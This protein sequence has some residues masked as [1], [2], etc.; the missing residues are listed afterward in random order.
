MSYRKKSA[1]I[2]GMVGPGYDL[3]SNEES[4]WKCPYSNVILSVKVTAYMY[5]EMH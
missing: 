1:D 5:V 2:C 3:V 4:K